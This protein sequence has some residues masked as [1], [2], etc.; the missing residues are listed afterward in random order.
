MRKEK[1]KT[2]KKILKEFKDFIARGNV[3]DMA[4]GVI[5]AGAFGKITTSLVND[6]LMPL[7]GWI[8]GSRDTT[9]LNIVVREAVM[10][11]E[12]VVQEAITIGFG[13]LVGTIID[14]LLVA[15][16]VFAIVKTMNTAKAKAEAKKKAEEAAAPP[17]PPA[18]SKEEV[19]LT[20]IRDL[21]KNK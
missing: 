3:L 18:P 4:I 19:L 1:L 9:A 13:T 21:L 8:T 15:L 10:D 14:F 16:V 12:T 6:V 2:M 17:A 11:G 5:I 7:I 20:E